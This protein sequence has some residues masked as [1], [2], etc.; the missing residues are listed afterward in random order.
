MRLI[1]S[2]APF[3]AIVT[4]GDTLAVGAIQALKAS[5]LRVPED[6]AVCGF[7]DIELSSLISPT[8]TTV[9]QPR[10][11]IGRRSMEKILDCISG[12]GKR[13]NEQIVLDYEIVIRQ[14]SGKYRKP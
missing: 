13:A 1:R 5:G 12:N 11:L 10:N 6:V 4:S 8:L 14:S 3:S 2:G 7:D 9:R